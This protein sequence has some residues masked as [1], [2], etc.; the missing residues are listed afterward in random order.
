MKICKPVNFQTL[1][2]L[3]PFCSR[4]SRDLPTFDVGQDRVLYSLF[5]VVEHSGSIHGGHYVAFVKV[6]PRLEEDSYRWQ[7]L[8]KNQARNDKTKGA[9]ADPAEPSGRWYYVSDSYVSEVSE[10]KVLNAQAYL[11]FYERIL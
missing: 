4:K 8:P 1:L 5:G 6:R 10:S 3:A 7:F 2:D 9:K 11:L